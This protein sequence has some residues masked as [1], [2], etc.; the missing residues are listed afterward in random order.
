M[1]ANI[2]GFAV[3]AI[4]GLLYTPY[5]VGKLGISVYGVVPLVMS[6]FVV[7]NWLSLAINWS[8]GR[9]LTIA[10][11]KGERANV[12]QIFSTAMFTS[13]VLVSFLAISAVAGAGLVH[14]ILRLPPG[15]EHAVSFLLVCGAVTTGLGIVEGVAEVGFY[16]MNRFDFQA[17]IGVGRGLGVVALVVFLFRVEGPRLE[18]IG[19]G[20]VAAGTLAAI[21]GFVWSRSLIPDLKLDLSAFSMKWLRTMIGTNVW[22]VVDQLGTILM[23]SLNLLL[24]NRLF[25]PD[26]SAEYALASQWE[27]VLRSVLGAVTVFAPTYV[28]MVA[29]DDI[30]GLRALSL[31]ASRLV[32]GIVAIGGGIIIGLAAP[33]ARVWL[34]RDTALVGP[35]IMGLL[36]PVVVNAA[37]NPLYGIWQA[38]N[39]VRLPSG[40]TLV[41][42]VISISV[43][44]LCANYT[45]LG[46]W[47]IVVGSATAFTARNLVFTFAYVGRLLNVSI[48]PFLRVTATNVSVAA[49]VAGLSYLLSVILH[50]SSWMS[51]VEVGLLCLV[52]AVP[53]FWFCTL[54]PNDR[55]K[56]LGWRTLFRRLRD[57]RKR[58]LQMQSSLD[59]QEQAK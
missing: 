2:L 27:S 59:S 22:V 5:L 39:R 13:L 25:G 54:E 30:E 4:V 20:S 24:A 9:Y 55:K 16:C 50:P 19:V 53:F 1:S 48:K 23:L 49:L 58:P 18:W 12:T 52:F 41:A 45:S 47:S 10:H 37:A 44:L 29:R 57:R 15:T 34:H 11:W 40:A 43:T 28:M 36:V 6:L 31:R 42:G 3:S 7:A 17:I 35:L 21:I 38:M 32:A 46:P 51:L 8:V 14:L 26:I 33:L 56:V